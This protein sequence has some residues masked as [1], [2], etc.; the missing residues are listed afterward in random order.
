MVPESVTEW[1]HS[2]TVSSWAF[3]L[4]LNSYLN[5]PG[6]TGIYFNTCI[7]FSKLE[8]RQQNN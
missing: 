3:E 7:G 2:R 8:F 4:Q 6:F 5:P 1:T